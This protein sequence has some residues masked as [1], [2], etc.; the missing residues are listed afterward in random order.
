MRVCAMSLQILFLFFEDIF[1]LD[2]IKGNKAEI[3]ANASGAYVKQQVLVSI[4]K[5]FHYVQLWGR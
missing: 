4:H 3:R 5:F 2:N 1:F